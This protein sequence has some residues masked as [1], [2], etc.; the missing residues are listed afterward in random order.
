M[1]KYDLVMYSDVKLVQYQFW[2]TGGWRISTNCVYKW[3]PGWTPE[4]KIITVKSWRLKNQK[5]VPWNGAKSVEGERYMHEGEIILWFAMDLEFIFHT[6]PFTYSYYYQINWLCINIS[7]NFLKLKETFWSLLVWYQN[8][9]ALCSI[10]LD[11][12]HRIHLH[13]PWCRLVLMYLLN[14]YD[15]V[16]SVQNRYET[17]AS[18]CRSIRERHGPPCVD[19]RK[20]RTSMC[21]YE[22][23]TDLHV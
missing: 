11:L 3:C 21:R 1:L 5:R 10:S 20:A 6:V 9:S 12:K 8:Q 22:K 18:M 23:G 16:S 14:I 13:L 15:A 7:F 2:C 19:T 17:R 4:K